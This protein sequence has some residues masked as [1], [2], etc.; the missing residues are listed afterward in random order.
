MLSAAFIFLGQ[1]LHLFGKTG[2]SN[3]IYRNFLFEGFPW[4][5]IGHFIHKH[6]K[7]IKLN[8]VLICGII[9]VS[10]LLCLAERA[11][12]F[13]RDFGINI[14][15]FPQAIA[16]FLFAVNNENVFEGRL[17]YVGKNLSLYVYVIHKPLWHCVE[18]VYKIIGLDSNPLALYIM[19]I[20][21]VI[22]SLVA[23]F[24]FYFVV[25]KFRENKKRNI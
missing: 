14:F 1:G 17:Q 4:F 11:F 19:P 15:N 21:V 25:K 12:I 18:F 6:Q 5:M 20:I 10:S 22:F 16:I 23:S 9:V 8:N 7:E 2:V 3:Y 13:D 24:V